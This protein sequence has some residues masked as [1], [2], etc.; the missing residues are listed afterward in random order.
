MKF[1]PNETLGLSRSARAVG[2]NRNVDNELGTSAGAVADGR[3]GAS[4][5]LDQSF[6]DREANA[7]ATAPFGRS[8]WYLLKQLKHAGQQ[9]R[10]DPPAV[11]SHAD[12]DLCGFGHCAQ[13]NVP[14]RFGKL[15]RIA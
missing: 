12:N 3:Y 14:A 13:S 11:V 5:Q 2:T 6:H 1:L 7:Q 10:G 8:G 15:N 4:M 9:V